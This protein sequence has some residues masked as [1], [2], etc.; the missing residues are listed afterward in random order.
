[1]PASWSSSES[2]PTATTPTRRSSSGRMIAPID[3]SQQSATKSWQPN[4]IERLREP[5]LTHLDDGTSLRIRIPGLGCT[6]RLP[7]H[8]R[9]RD[10]SGREDL[11]FLPGETHEHRSF[12]SLGPLLLMAPLGARMSTGFRVRPPMVLTSS[13]CP[14]ARSSPVNGSP[15]RRTTPTD[16]L[17]TL[18][19]SVH[20]LMP[21]GSAIPVRRG[22]V[23]DW[24]RLRP[25]QLPVSLA[26]CGQGDVGQGRTIRRPESLASRP[27]STAG[28]PKSRVT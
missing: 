12:W 6:W 27:D 23:G 4:L 16:R 10:G 25:R 1:M 9:R 18:R 3:S 14:T 8:I 5:D 21:S 15:R 7:V 13:R 20:A 11:D 22:W 2:S 24:A 19:S 26:Q 17:V 28:W